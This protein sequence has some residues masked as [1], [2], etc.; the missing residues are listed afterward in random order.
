ME[1]EVI[2]RDVLGADDDDVYI[3]RLVPLLGLGCHR[4]LWPQFLLA[5]P[6]QNLPSLES[7]LRSLFLFLSPFPSHSFLGF[8]SPAPFP[9]PSRLRR[10]FA[11]LLFSSC[12]WFLLP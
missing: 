1:S 7:I 10:Y 4:L 9:S 12:S 3:P 5:S 2:D 6:A 11:S 8:S